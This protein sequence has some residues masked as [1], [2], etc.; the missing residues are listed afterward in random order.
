M[1]CGI[2]LQ[3]HEGEEVPGPECQDD[4]VLGTTVAVF[5]VVTCNVQFVRSDVAA[6]VVRNLLENFEVYGAIKLRHPI[7]HSPY[8]DL[9]EGFYGIAGTTEYDQLQGS[10]GIVGIRK[11][12]RGVMVSMSFDGAIVNLWPGCGE[13]ASG[14][15]DDRFREEL[16]FGPGS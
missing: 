12:L 14:L 5:P 2:P 11:G 15:V 7:R 13:F 16:L 3:I 6:G 9:Q 10:T 1:P 8:A 4:E